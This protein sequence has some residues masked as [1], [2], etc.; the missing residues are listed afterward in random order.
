MSVSQCGT[1]SLWHYCF[2]YVGAL[3]VGGA[4]NTAVT[5]TVGWGRAPDVAALRL[6]GR[7]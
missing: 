5:L 4:K 3:R 2:E 1:L 7:E 6:V